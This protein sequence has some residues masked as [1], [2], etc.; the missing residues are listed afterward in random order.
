LQDGWGKDRVQEYLLEIKSPDNPGCDGRLDGEEAY[1]LRSV[2]QWG[3]G[4]RTNGNLVVNPGIVLKK[5]ETHCL[6]FKYSISISN[7]NYK[8]TV[9]D[10]QGNENGNKKTHIS[11]SGSNLGKYPNFRKRKPF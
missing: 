10:S 2:L 11:L 6:T 8:T 5:N 7:Y 9:T 3:Y 1:R 4:W